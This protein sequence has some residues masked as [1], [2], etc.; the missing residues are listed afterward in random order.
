VAPPDATPVQRKNF[1]NVQ[2]DAIGIGVASAAAQFL[3]V[4]LARMG[5]TNFQ[6]GLLTAMPA[7]TGLFLAIAVGRIL[8]SR[9]QIVPWFSAARLLVISAYALTGLAPFIVPETL[10]VPAVLLIWM[11]ATLPQI[12]V[13]VAFSVV[14]NAVAGPAKRYELMSRRWSLLGLTAAIT[15]ALTGQVLDRIDFPINYQIVFIGLSAGGLISYYFSSHIRLPDIQPPP[16]SSGLSFRQRWKEQFGLILNE[17]PFVSFTLKR[18]VFLTGQTLAVPLFPLYFVREV[19]ASN[20]WIGTINTAQTAVLLFGYFFWT[21]QSRRRGSRFVLLWTTF[22][23]ALYP[24]VIASTLQV[25]LIA[26]YAGLAG[27]LQAGIDLV[28]FDELMKT[29]PEEYSATFVSWAQSAQYLSSVAAPLLGTLLATWIGLSGALV[30]S[31]GVRLV[32]FALFAWGK[33]DAG[34]PFDESVPS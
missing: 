31:T 19:Q 26:L 7:F 28:F 17:R 2:I 1:L 22:G 12:V 3:P 25:E 33:K 4:Y 6:V 14:M 34:P 30:V 29:V 10:V 5:A 11:V 16:S 32:G 24:A 15:V 20:A 8:Q 27:I 9:R 18:L 13:N 23:L 21:R